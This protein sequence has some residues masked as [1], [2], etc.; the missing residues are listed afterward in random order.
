VDVY[1]LPTY[2]VRL[3][4]PPQLFDDLPETVTAIEEFIDRGIL[5][6]VKALL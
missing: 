3:N 6:T 4:E 5:P 2:E 1:L